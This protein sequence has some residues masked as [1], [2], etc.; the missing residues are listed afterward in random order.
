MT[1]PSTNRMVKVDR[2]GIEKQSSTKAFLLVCFCLCLCF[3]SF[4][5]EAIDAQEKGAKKR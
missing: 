4:P 5:L 2:E 3:C 1:P